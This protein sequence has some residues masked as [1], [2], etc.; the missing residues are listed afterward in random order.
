MRIT[1]FDVEHGACALVES[2]NNGPIALIDCGHNASTGWN[3]AD[4]IRRQLGRDYLDYLIITNADQDHYSALSRLMA[5]LRV[6]VFHKNP[7]VTVPIF[8]SLKAERGPLSQDAQAYSGLLN[9]HQSLDFIEFDH[10]MGGVTLK[11][12]WNSYPIFTDLNNLSLA[13]FVSFGSFRILFPGD[14]EGSGWLALLADPVFRDYLRGSTILVASHHGR[15]SGYCPEAF[16][17]WS[18]QAVVVSDKPI[19]Y[20]SQDVPQYQ[21]VIAGDGVIVKGES[22]LRHVLTTRNDGSVMF[23]VGPDGSYIIEVERLSSWSIG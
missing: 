19:M 11:T 20:K 4:Y 14:V 13:A 5:S 15:A 21:N 9:S 8:Q 18:P 10:A 22:R 17:D 6:G 1:I 2:P 23:S 12:F 7:T 3:P 16:E